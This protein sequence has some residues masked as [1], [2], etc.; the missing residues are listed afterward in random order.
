MGDSRIGQIGL[1][2][3]IH[4]VTEPVFETERVPI[5][6]HFMAESIARETLTRR[7]TVW[8]MSVQVGEETV[9]ISQPSFL[10]STLSSLVGS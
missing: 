4:V 8:E 5:P 2:V 6:L 1:G 7:W 10:S 9:T 3:P